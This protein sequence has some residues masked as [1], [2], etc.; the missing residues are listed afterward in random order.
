MAT[1]KDQRVSN[2][3]REIEQRFSWKD[4]IDNKDVAGYVLG[5]DPSMGKWGRE[6]GKFL[7][8]SLLAIP[9]RDQDQ[10]RNALARMNEPD[11][12]IMEATIVAKSLMQ[13]NLYGRGHNGSGS[14][15]W[16]GWDEMPFSKYMGCLVLLGD[17]LTI[18]PW[19]SPWVKPRKEEVGAPLSRTERVTR[20]AQWDDQQQMYAADMGR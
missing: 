7:G 11:S 17:H 10:V 5:N 12:G 13:R 4:D 20:Q 6:I 19:D 15:S 14:V 2:D 3:E 18:A 9:C 16:L 1:I 8:R